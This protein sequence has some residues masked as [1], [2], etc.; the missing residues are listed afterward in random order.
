MPQAR[1]STTDYGRQ[2]PTNGIAIWIIPVERCW[3][4]TLF[5]SDVVMLRLEPC[6]HRM[7][8]SSPMVGDNERCCLGPCAIRIRDW[9]II[10]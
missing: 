6:L 9:G 1:R 8:N 5:L 10:L 3:E 7:C 2:S 4:C